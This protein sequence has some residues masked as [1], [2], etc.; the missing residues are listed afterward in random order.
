MDQNEPLY[1]RCKKLEYK[2]WIRYER[3][4]KKYRSNN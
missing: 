2:S 1:N 3:R 4:F